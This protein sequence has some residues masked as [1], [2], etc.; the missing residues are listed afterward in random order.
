M[1]EIHTTFCLQ[2]G[3]ELSGI[4]E[5]ASRMLSAEAELLDLISESQEIPH[6]EAP[7]D[8]SFLITFARSR[9]LLYA[10]NPDRYENSNRKN[11]QPM[12][13]QC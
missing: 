9:R 5:V 7:F 12:I 3:Y 13:R 8:P 4:S 11:L 6:S 1:L 10:L 2:D